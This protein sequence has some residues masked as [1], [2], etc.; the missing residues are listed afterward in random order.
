MITSKLS[1]VFSVVKPEYVYLKLK[2][3]NSIRNNS[4][5]KLARSMA[6]MYK[7]ILENIEKKEEKIVK[8]L[9]KDYFVPTRLEFHPNAKISYYIYMEHKKIEF[10]FIVP[11]HQLLFIKE[12]ITDVWSHI[13]IEQ[14]ESIPFFSPESSKLQIYYKKEDALSLATDRRSN[15]LLN[16]NLNVVEMMEEN[17]KLGIFY[18]FIPTTQF[19]WRS[20]HRTTIEKYKSNKP[21]ERD[22]SGWRYIFKW[23]ISAIDTLLTTVSESLLPT[24][25]SKQIKSDDSGIING[26]ITALNK[27]NK[28]Q[29]TDATLKKSNAAVLNT[30]IV[31]LAESSDK[32]RQRNQIRSLAQSFDTITADNELTYKPYNKHFNPNDYSIGSER[33]VI[34]DEEAQNFLSI[35]GRDVLEKYNFIESVETFET[36]VP[37]D[38]R[39][40]VMCIGE[41]IYRGKSQRAYLSNDREFRNLLTLLIGPSRSGKSNLLSH[42]C[43]DAIEAGESIVLFDF[44]EA[45]QMSDEI[46]KCFPNNKILDIRCDDFNNL[47]GLGFN[48]VGR[49]SDVF[50]QYENAKRQTSNMITLINS[51]NTDDS[52]LSPKM[53]RYLESASLVVFINNGSIKDVFGVLLNHIL[54]H[55]YLSDIPRTQKENLEEYIESLYELDEHDKEGNITGSKLNLVVGIIDR[56]NSLKRNTYTELMLKKDTT[57]NINLVEE[58]QKNQLIIIRLP[59]HMFTTST[60]KDTLVLYFLQ[61]LWLASQIR[62]EKIKDK[63]QRVKCNVIFDEIYQLPNTEKFLTSKLSQMA[64]FIIKPIISAHY[65]LQLKF[66]REEIRSANSSYVILA[67]ADK[68][69]FDELKSELYPFTEDDLRNLPRYHSLNYVKC[70]DGYARFITKLPGDVSKRIRQNKRPSNE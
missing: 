18:N 37:E 69:N 55:R 21:I 34:G 7:N 35:A 63:S 22:K 33:N 52:R 70:K 51:V 4:T 46:S 36:E 67:G 20:K 40:G 57:N 5:H 62:A 59:E 32:F 23:T 50:K 24:S 38:L 3:N 8:L 26:F 61:K 11:K 53:E 60:E 6:N 47:Q 54:R 66:M 43:I 29:L 45:C 49:S 58:I 1:E 28:Q 30:Q 17:D 41:N 12:K 19:T 64:K 13:T 16:S 9:G 39:S 68:K 15:D 42:M 48:E 25:S 31:V 44:I 10:Y 27:N 2:P 14:V 56:L 65:L